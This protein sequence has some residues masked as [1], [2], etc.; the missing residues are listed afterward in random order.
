[1]AREQ[2]R[3]VARRERILEAALAVFARRGYRDAAMDEIAV[4]ADTSKGGLY[5]HFP[6]KQ[7]LFF[8]LLDRTADLLMSRAEQAI[9][10]EVDPARQIDAALAIVFRTFASHRALARL[11]LVDALGAGPEAH[12]KL[13]EIHQRFARLIARHL[14][15]AIAAGAVAPL[16]TQLAGMAWLGAINE[17][18]TSWVLGGKPEH[19]DDAYPQLRAFLRRSVGLP[20]TP[21]VT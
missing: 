1:M 3:A 16:D 13:M 2:R 4:E 19:L 7:A 8:T 15:A 12:L 11:F 14:E 21:E 20:E 5:F 9:A 10:A 17:V 6:T 18:V